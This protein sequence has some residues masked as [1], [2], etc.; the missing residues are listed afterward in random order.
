MGLLSKLWGEKETA[1]SAVLRQ[2][3]DI[4]TCAQ[5]CDDCSSKYPSSLKIEGGDLWNSTKPYGLHI[6]VFTGKSDWPH[7]A[8]G[9]SGSFE[10]E[11][12]LWGS[13]WDA[14]IPS[15]GENRSEIGSIKVSA[16]SLCPDAPFGDA[17]YYDGKKGDLL[18]LPFF[19]KIVGVPIAHVKP[20][21]S[22]YIPLLIDARASRLTTIPLLPHQFHEI[23]RVELD[24]NQA[25]IFLCSH[26]TRDRRCGVT[27]PIMKKELDIHLRDKGLFR[28]PGDLAPDGVS[29]SFINHV[30]GHKF[31][32]NVLVY[33]RAPLLVIW[34]GRATPA[35]ALPIIDECVLHNRVWP[36]SLRLAERFDDIEW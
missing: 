5:E 12:A 30:G 11:V 2:G 3:F 29:V 32:A 25:H 15:G 14:P 31:S 33:K 19:V 23:A 20:L 13:L 16:S 9:E 26:K 35:N 7:D 4:S 18:V 8:C 27:A 21:L 10:H 36:L 34:I 22:L 28:D 1:E 24:V 6:L 17:D